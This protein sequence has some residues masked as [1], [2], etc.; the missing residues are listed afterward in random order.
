MNSRFERETPL[1]RLLVGCGAVAMLAVAGLAPAAASSSGSKTICVGVVVDPR[2]IGGTVNAR[3]ATVAAGSTGVDVLEAAGHTVTFRPR[4][5]LLCTIDGLPKS[6]CGAVDDTHY[7]AYYH[8]AP[9]GTTWMYSNEGAGT[10]QPANRSTEGWVY[11]DGTSLKPD[12]IPARQ[13][14]AGLLKPTPTPTPTPVRSTTPHPASTRP[15]RHG[16]PE[17]ASPGP[18]KTATTN[19][20]RPQTS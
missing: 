3:C 12:N 10:Y 9:D 18:P 14:C 11:D 1:R 2:A 13:I 16:Y 4:D 15:V 19:T 7:W 20:P 8:R 5:G 6:G 17:H